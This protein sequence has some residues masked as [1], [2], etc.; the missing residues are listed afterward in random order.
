M[1]RHFLFPVV[2]MVLLV[3]MRVY[4]TIIIQGHEFFIA[5]ATKR[6]FI[7]RKKEQLSTPSHRKKCHVTEH[8][9]TH[10]IKCDMHFFLFKLLTIYYI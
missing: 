7:L 2:K 10:D 8:N 5:T 1:I 6:N 9:V 3:L 4:K